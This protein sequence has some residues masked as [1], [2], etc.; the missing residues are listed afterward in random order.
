MQN[1]I[2]FQMV[3]QERPSTLTCINSRDYFSIIEPKYEN[4]IMLNNLNFFII[5]NNYIQNKITSNKIK[6]HVISKKK[7]YQSMFHSKSIFP[8]LLFPLSLTNPSHNLK[9]FPSV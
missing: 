1:Q 6:I 9:S 3:I 7:K 4:V 5:H 8:T 2:S